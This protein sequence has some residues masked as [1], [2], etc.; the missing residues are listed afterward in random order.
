[1][2]NII[3]KADIATILECVEILTIRGYLAES[4]RLFTTIKHRGSCP[5][6]GKENEKD[7][8]WLCL[9]CIVGNSFEQWLRLHPH[10]NR[11]K[12]W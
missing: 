8:P 6:C 5:F 1:M 12:Y 7:I 3:N 10:V 9:D 4:E 2:D 11:L